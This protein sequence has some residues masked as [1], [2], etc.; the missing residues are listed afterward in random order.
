MF[1]IVRNLQWPPGCTGRSV[2]NEFSESWTGRE[3]DLGVSAD[4]IR[5]RFQRA[6]ETGDVSTAVVW[7]GEIIDLV[8]SIRPAGDI[9]R[10]MV[11]EAGR[12][13]SAGPSALL[14]SADEPL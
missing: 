9:L 7:A 8:H 3:Q 13:L 12:L 1:D 14:P 10:D 5:G 6:Q 11:S 2:R 4:E